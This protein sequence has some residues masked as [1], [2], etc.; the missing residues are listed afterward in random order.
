M[1]KLIASIKDPLFVTREYDLQFIVVWALYAG[2]GIAAAIAGIPTISLVSGALYN[3][4]WASGLATF[5]IGALLSS[6]SIFFKTYMSQQT[7]KRLERFF[8][9]GV[10]AV[11][12]VYPGFLLLLVCIGDTERIATFIV[13]LMYVWIPTIRIRHLSRRIK[14]YESLRK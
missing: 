2:W 11:V 6:I 7:K 5:A 10:I 9:W 8:L 14:Y 12:A 1:P 13:A 4:L 3:T